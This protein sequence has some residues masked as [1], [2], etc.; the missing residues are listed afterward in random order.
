MASDTYQRLFEIDFVPKSIHCIASSPDVDK[1]STPALIFTH[2]A[3]GTLSSDG[4]AHFAK[5]F[6]SQLPLVCFQGN[7]NLNSRIN[8]FNTVSKHNNFSTCLGGRSMGARA[9]VKAA[10]KNTKYLVLISYP[11]H[12]DKVVRDQILLDL[13]SS[14]EVIFVTGDRDSMCN[15]DRLEE[16][17]MK[18]S[19]KTWRVVVRDADHGMNVR[20]SKGTMSVG[21]KTGKVVASWISDHFDDKREGKINWNNQENLANWSGWCSKPLDVDDAMHRKDMS[22]EPFMESNPTPLPEKTRGK[23]KAERIHVDAGAVSRRTRKRVK[24]GSPV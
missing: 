8:M 17:R 10:S 14:T 2:G 7:I 12:T 15:L 5:G 23:K 4:I 1:A 13:S 9:A 6:S 22:S 21:E 24:C 3:G 16:V 18:M 20:P 11:L 19:C